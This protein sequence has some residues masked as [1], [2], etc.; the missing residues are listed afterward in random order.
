MYKYKKIAVQIFL[1]NFL[2]FF[3]FRFS[4]YRGFEIHEDDGLEYICVTI[5]RKKGVEPL[6]FT[7][8]GEG[9]KKFRGNKRR[10]NHPPPPALPFLLFYTFYLARFPLR[11][12]PASTILGRKFLSPRFKL[13]KEFLY[14]PLVGR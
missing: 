7:M 9:S 3:L 12:A 1:Q 4:L 8:E 2:F 13:L 5:R 6:K 11:L 14:C 10:S